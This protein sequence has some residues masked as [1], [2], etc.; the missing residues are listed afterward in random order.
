MDHLVAMSGKRVLLLGYAG[1]GNFGDDLLL[2]LA[3]EAI[4]RAGPHEITIHTS[5]TGDRADYLGKWFPEARLAKGRLTGGLVSRHERVLY[6]GGGVLFD[7]ERLRMARRLRRLVSEFRIFTLP[8]L[9]GGVAFGGIG[10]GLGPFACKAGLALAGRR[11]RPFGILGV[12]DEVSL[13]LA[14]AQGAT[15]ARLTPDLSLVLADG[16]QPLCADHAE[17]PARPRILVCPRHYPHGPRKDR[18]LASLELA[19]QGIRKAIPGARVTAFGFQGRHDE[20]ALDRIG[21][22][23]DDQVMWD[24]WKMEV[25]DVLR[26][27]AAQDL[28]ISSRM[29]GI[30]VAGMAGTPSV[31]IGVDPKLAY[32]AGFFRNSEHVEDTAAAEAIVTAA[33][34]ALAMP[35]GARACDHLAAHAA[36]CAEEYRRM[37][38]WIAGD[39]P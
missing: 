27:F 1:H 21:K 19:I 34:R 35:R 37:T 31:A 17:D 5:A 30:F 2:G 3:V 38:G 8:R 14:R 10:M 9:L 24:P 7:Y 26:L 15:Q 18:Y 16:S 11:I 20:E 6:F 28:V 36:A 29:H 13:G 32:A 23:A 4:R 39:A 12:R 22:G 33:H 25:R